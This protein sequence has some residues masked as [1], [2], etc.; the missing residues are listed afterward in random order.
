[1]KPFKSFYL[2]EVKKSAKPTVALVS[3]S[4]KPPHAGHLDMVK[5]YADMADKVTVIISDPKKAQSIRKTSTGTVITADIAKAIWDIYIKATGLKNVEA[6]VSYLPSPVTAA[7]E[8]AKDNLA[9]HKVIFGA[10]K[11]DNDYKRWLFAPKWFAQHAPDVE[12]ID[13]ESVAVEPYENI[14]AT[15]IRDN[16]DKPE[17]IRQY[18]PKELS[19]DD[20]NKIIDLLS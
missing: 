12:I 17:E 7:S 18:F 14:S 20:F 11:K 19:D 13:P 9:N 6:V 8:Y 15:T 2:N 16:L 5:K 10:S 1:M 3:G 4:F